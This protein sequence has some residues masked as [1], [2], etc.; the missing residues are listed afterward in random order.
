MLYNSFQNGQPAI[1]VLGFAACLVK[2]AFV[3]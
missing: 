1:I 2:R 3:L